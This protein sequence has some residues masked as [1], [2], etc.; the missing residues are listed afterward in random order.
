MQAI[1]CEQPGGRAWSRTLV[2]AIWLAVSLAARAQTYLVTDL[3]TN[4][5]PY[6]IND[7]GDVVGAFLGTNGTH[8]FFFTNG[9]ATICNSNLSAANSINNLDQSVGYYQDVSGI[10]S[11]LTTNSATLGDLGVGI[12][13]GFPIMPGTSPRWFGAAG[14]NDAGQ[15]VGT[16]LHGTYLGLSIYRGYLIA[17]G[18]TND[19]PTLGISPSDFSLG[20]AISQNGTVAYMAGTNFN[21]LSPFRACLYTNGVQFVLPTPLTTAAWVSSVNDSNQ[22]VGYLRITTNVSA[23]NS[24]QVF[25]WDGNTLTNIGGLGTNFASSVYGL[26]NYGQV[27]GA[28]YDTNRSPPAYVS[29]L[30]DETNGI[31]DLNTMLAP[32]SGWTLRGPTAINDAG[33]ITGWGLTNGVIHGFLLTPGL[34]FNP[35]SFKYDKHT[36][37]VTLTISGLNGQSVVLQASCGLTGWVSIATN[38]ISMNR[39]TFSDSG[40]CPGGAVRYYR[41]VVVQ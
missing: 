27:V 34:I 40:T 8:A 25:F 6:A 22:V 13:D 20:G 4:V 38:T 9:V 11:F 15:I 3:G 39:T 21:I 29:F 12:G 1:F 24:Q 26:N 28:T 14:I 17:N 30:Y 23:V 7:N 2:G 5:Q 35:G 10:R 33:Q 18:A 37:T 36:G 16:R 31:A 19:L 41:A 32:G